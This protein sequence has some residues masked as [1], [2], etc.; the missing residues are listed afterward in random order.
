MPPGTQIDLER[1]L[2]AELL[3]HGQT[4]YRRELDGEAYAEES[5]LAAL[6]LRSRVAAPLLVGARTTGLISVGRNTPD[7]FREDEIELV[8]L[9][10]RLLASAVQNIRAYDSER[11]TVEEL[12]RLSVLRAD[13]VSLVS[14]EMRSPMAAVI[15]AARTLQQ[16][17][18]ELRPEQRE[19]FLALI[20]DETTRLAGLIGDVLDTSRIDAGTFS[21]RFDDVDVGALVRDSV[22]T[23]SVGQ[24]EVPI[25]SEIPGRLPVVRGD[26][27]RLRQVLTNMIDNAVKYS[28]PGQPVQVRVAHSN[29]SLAVS[30]ADR[31]PGIDWADQRL[32]FEKFGRVTGASSKP[33]TGLGLYIARSIAEAHGG[34]LAV[35]SALGRGA[36]FTLMLPV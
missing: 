15:G 4:V 5:R 30:V 29:G 12:R 25:I 16:R 31:G 28:P 27:D 36:V 20:G 18:R 33:G 14:H 6:G 35:S 19:A 8:S 3:V 21:F 13:F 24:D 1:N 2:L 26:A 9:L 11:R 34:T 32:I 23:A 10:G 17:W 7:A 22:T